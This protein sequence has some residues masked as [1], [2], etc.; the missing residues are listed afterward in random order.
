MPTMN[1]HALIDAL[2]AWADDLDYDYS[3]ECG[4]SCN[5]NGAPQSDAQ[6]LVAELHALALTLNAWSDGQKRFVEYRDNLNTTLQTHPR[7]T[8]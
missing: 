4:E 8:I 5:T 6:R 3:E 7:N 1:I 2:N